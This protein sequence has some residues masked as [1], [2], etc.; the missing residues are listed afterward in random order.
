M[1]AAMIIKD[2]LLV[3]PLS[4]APVGHLEVRVASIG[5][6]QGKIQAIGSYDAVR[7]ACSE[8]EP[9]IDACPDGKLRYLALPG[10]VD[11]HSHSRQMALQAYWDSGWHDRTSRPQ[12]AAEA[13]DLF[14]WF[15]LEAVKGGVTFVCDW[16]EHPHLWDPHPLDLQLRDC[17]LRGCLR[18]LLPHNR[19]AALPASNEAAARLQ[20]A[21][22]ETDDTLQLAVWIPE[23]DKPEYHH[24]MLAQL[25]QL[26][27]SVDNRSL[28]FQ[29]HLAESRSRKTADAQALARL[30][31]HGLLGSRSGA[32][33]LLIHA[34]WIDAEELC[35]LAELR[36]R[37]GVVTC[38]KFTDG[39]VAPLRELLEAGVPVGLG[40]DVSVP[41]P[42]ELIRSLV[43][44]HKSRQPEH[45][46]SFAEAFHMATLGGATLFGLQSQIGSLE[47]GKDADLVLLRNSTAV[48]PDL[49]A[50]NASSTTHAERINAVARL[51]ARNVLRREHIDKVFVRGQILVDNGHC[52]GEEAIAT[53]GIRA[54]RAIVGRIIRA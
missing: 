12:D 7:R 40:S 27:A 11:A 1:R 35:R 13:A 49:F 51:L 5:V 24:A 44:L 38:P 19:G 17:G 28:V 43:A 54:A 48:I 15:L 46:L 16:P 4:Q 18:L 20:A 47:E 36:D 25:G 9:L 21:L 22:R 34:I 50:S 39:R 45:Q 3:T 26:R 2:A 37:V 41:D 8:H 31:E 42:L 29:M 53:A 33:T 10:F 30:I 14:R 6:A 52:A 23:E 32:R